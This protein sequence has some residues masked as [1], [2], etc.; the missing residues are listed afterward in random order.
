MVEASGVGVRSL[1]ERLSPRNLPE[2]MLEP[3]RK[4]MKSE[5]P[6]SIGESIAGS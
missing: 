4:M 3:Q 1:K 6:E 2:V 5:C